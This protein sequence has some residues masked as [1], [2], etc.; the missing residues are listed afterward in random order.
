[1]TERLVFPTWSLPCISGWL[2]DGDTRRAQRHLLKRPRTYFYGKHSSMLPEGLP[3]QC[4]PRSKH[5]Y[6]WR[7]F[8]IGAGCWAARIVP[9]THRGGFSGKY[10]PATGMGCWRESKLTRPRNLLR[11]GNCNTAATTSRQSRLARSVWP[12][13]NQ[14]AY[15]RTRPDRTQCH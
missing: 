8:P 10:N 3:S 14:L 13:N 2:L 1:M 5:G 15:R 12:T 9:G 11:A 6:C 7:S 4:S